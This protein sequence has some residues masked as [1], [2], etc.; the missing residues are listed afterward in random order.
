LSTI[1]CKASTLKKFSDKTSVPGV[2]RNDL[3]RIR[4]ALPPLLEQRKIA[5]ILNTWDRAIDLTEQLIAAKQQRK[6]GLMQQLLTGKRR[7]VEFEGA[8]WKVDSLKNIAIF[9]MVNHRQ[10]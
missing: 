6:K 8:E 5:E 3:H 9:T 4:V 2:N 1:C 7:F 10:G